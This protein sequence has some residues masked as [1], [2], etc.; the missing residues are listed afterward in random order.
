M[1][2]GTMLIFR[3]GN[4]APEAKHYKQSPSLEELHTAVGGYLEIVPDFKTI[5][6]AGTVMNCQAL[7]NENGK[8]NHLPVNEGATYAWEH[9]LRREGLSLLDDKTRTY[10]DYLVGQIAV[11]FGDAEFMASL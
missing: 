2:R 10:K 1:M 9:A 6:Y 7:C 3:P 4:S 8:L 11:L 5:A